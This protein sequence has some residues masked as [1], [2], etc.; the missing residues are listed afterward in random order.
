M[1]ADSLPNSS[2]GDFV[3]AKEPRVGGVVLLVTPLI[4]QPQALASPAGGAA[5]DSAPVGTNT[6]LAGPWEFTFEGRIGVPTDRLKVGEFPTGSAKAGG[7]G[8]PGTLFRLRDLGID[9]SE[10]LEGS[11][12]FH[13]TARDAV[14]A[15][16]LPSA[17][18]AAILRRSSG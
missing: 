18:H 7:G 6:A 16:Y 10:A 15:S 1:G 5:L 9:V 11:A 12:A 13:L 17:P 2:S 8:T 14:R 3:L 4:C